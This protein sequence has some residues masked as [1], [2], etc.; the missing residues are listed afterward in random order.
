MFY[1]QLAATEFLRAVAQSKSGKA[2]FGCLIWQIGISLTKHKECMKSTK[3]VFISHVTEQ[4]EIA[5]LLQRYIKSIYS[6]VTKIFVSSDIRSNPAGGDWLETIKNSLRDADV[7]IAICSKDSI[8]RPWINLEA[9]YP[10]VA[11]KPIICLYHSGLTRDQAPQ[12]Y[13]QLQGLN[14]SDENFA[15]DFF[16]S[17]GTY[18]GHQSLP[19][20]ELKAFEGELAKVIQTTSKPQI[21]NKDLEASLSSDNDKLEEIEV[22]ILKAFSSSGERE[23]TSEKI[24]S[25]VNE[26]FESGRS[27]IE[28]E[29]YLA[30]LVK[31]G[32]I[33]EKIALEYPATYSLDHR[34]REYLVRN[35]LLY[36]KIVSNRD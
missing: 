7:H 3:S 17:L 15:H 4:K 22:Y 12:P 2:S 34:G 9:G 13:S 28:I 18:L 5:F 21:I 33:D 19:A 29:Y 30:K 31:D 6:S 26:N 27:D 23:L 20:H 35:G 24:A 11:N 36:I 32:F 10:F 14:T 16:S 1:L 25:K 8:D